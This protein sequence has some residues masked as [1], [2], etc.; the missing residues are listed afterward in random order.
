MLGIL[1]SVYMLYK[2]SGCSRYRCIVYPV[3][4]TVC[5]AL[6]EYSIAYSRYVVLMCSAYMRAY[7]VPNA[8]NRMYVSGMVVAALVLL[9]VEV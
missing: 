8:T 4:R 3:L 7:L 6:A 9:V 5:V 1:R 2:Y